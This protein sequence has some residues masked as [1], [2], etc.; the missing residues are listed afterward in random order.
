[1]RFFRANSN[2]FFMEESSSMTI[3]M[4]SHVYAHVITTWH[5]A[6]HIH[7]DNGM[8]QGRRYI[9]YFQVIHEAQR[10]VEPRERN[11]VVEL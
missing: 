9:H 6:V 10:R 7:S 3:H 5:I 2:H 1:M 8:I 4:I 11:F